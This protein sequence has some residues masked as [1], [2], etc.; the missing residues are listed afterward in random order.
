MTEPRPTADTLRTQVIDELSNVFAVRSVDPVQFVLE[1]NGR[2]IP[3]RISANQIDAYM[4]GIEE[5]A[6]SAMGMEPKW[7]S[8]LSLVAVHILEEV[9]MAELGASV[10]VD[11]LVIRR[12]PPPG[13]DPVD[14]GE[15]TEGW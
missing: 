5:S 3:V 13:A 1:K 9:A 12:D 6:F 8:S 14:G 15:S 11:G 4:T 10:I 2:L 7:L